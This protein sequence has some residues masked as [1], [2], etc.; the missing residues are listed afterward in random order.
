MRKTNLFYIEDNKSNFLTFSNYGEYLTGVCLSTNHKIFPASFICLDLPFNETHTLDEFKK[1]LM[2]YYE[3]KLAWIRDQFDIQ[4]RK[5]ED[6]R[7]ELNYLLEAIYLFFDN[8][9]IDIKYFGDIVEHDY[10][11][12]YN[13]SICIVDF[14]KIKKSNISYIDIRNNVYNKQNLNL[15]NWND[16]LDINIFHAI[17]DIDIY[18]EDNPNYSYENSD[19]YIENNF[20]NFEDLE[21]TETQYND[22]TEISFNCIIPLFD[23]INVSIEEN[24]DNINEDFDENNK[25]KRIPYGI[26]F[27]SEKSDNTL[28][29][30][31]LYKNNDNISQS[32]SLV[33]SSKFAPY[34]LGVKIDDNNIDN[35]EKYTYAELLSKNSELLEKYNDLTEKY[36]DILSEMSLLKNKINNL[37]QLGSNSVY[38]LIDEV[39]DKLYKYDV[40]FN[41]TI[42]ELKEKF[43]EQMNSLKWKA[44][45][46]SD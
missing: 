38:S 12:T 41:S 20:I 28:N 40:T 29:N 36:F 46:T 33:I 27:S 19:V 35:I 37:E 11:G 45:N 5:F 43:D 25:Y 9:T 6:S 44:I 21:N 34:P 10:N 8:N 17:T 16:E 4:D 1:F 14:N 24:T 30:I 2:C 26:W 23:V 15:Y 13:D 42:K 22:K 7:Q 31:T 32:W 3:N 39:N 18:I